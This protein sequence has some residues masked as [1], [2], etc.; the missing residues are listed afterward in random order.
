MYTWQPCA[1]IN[2]RLI[3][4]GSLC[5]S[6]AYHSN[7]THRF[8]IATEFISCKG[9]TPVQLQDVPC[10]PRL[11][12]CEGGRIVGLR[13]GGICVDVA[14]GYVVPMSSLWRCGESRLFFSLPRFEGRRAHQHSSDR[15]PGFGSKQGRLR[16]NWLN[17]EHSI[18][19]A[20]STKQTKH[21]E[22]F[23]LWEMPGRIWH[24]CMKRFEQID[25]L[26]FKLFG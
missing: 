3:L 25:R 8:C 23:T 2:S 26:W 6:D 12:I 11:E 13:P 10:L 22:H 9:D 15:Y 16:F 14:L 17:L 5:I 1:N 24:G 19:L 7:S 20:L 4:L 18:R 21:T